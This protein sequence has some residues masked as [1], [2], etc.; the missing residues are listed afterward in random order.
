MWTKNDELLLAA[1]IY[2]QELERVS[3]VMDVFRTPMRIKCVRGGRGAAAKS[4]S[5]ASLLIQ[6]ANRKPL[7]IGCFREVQRSLEESSF[8]LLEQTIKRLG[9]PG[10]R[11]TNEFLKSPCGSHIIFRGLR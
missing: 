3:P 7:R 8:A 4:W 5:I 6:N 11:V 2:Q 10:W 1:L 9:Y